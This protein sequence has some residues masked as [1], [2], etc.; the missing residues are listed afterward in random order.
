[1]QQGLSEAILARISIGAASLADAQQVGLASARTEDLIEAMKE[2]E[3]ATAARLA[4]VIGDPMRTDLPTTSAGPEVLVPVEDA[5]SLHARA[6][7]HPSV[8][9]FESLAQAQSEMARSEAAASYPSFQL[10]ADW[11]LVDKAEFGNPPDS[12][13]DAVMVSGGVSL[14]LWGRSYSRSEQAARARAVSSQA[15]GRASEYEQY[16][17]LEGALAE[18]RDAARRVNLHEN[19]LVP[20]AE[21]AYDSVLGAYVAGRGSVSATLMVQQDLLDLRIGLETARADHARAWARLEQVV[22]GAVA[23]RQTP[24]GQEASATVTSPTETS[25]METNSTGTSTGGE[26]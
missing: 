14:P 20:Q 10:G 25:P 16:A 6:A 1:V 11:I 18:L 15:Q 3:R 5:A 13:K 4:A 12:G 22:G 24:L 19:T 7:K 17:A 2:Q 23:G 26:Q 9:Q 8:T 21:A